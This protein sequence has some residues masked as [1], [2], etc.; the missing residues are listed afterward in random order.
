MAQRDILMRQKMETERLL[1][2]ERNRPGIGPWEP[3]TVTWYGP[4]FNGKI[5]ADGTVYNQESPTCA[6]PTLPLGTVLIVK[7]P[8]GEMV[9]LIVTDR[10]PNPSNPN[11]LDVSR[12]AARKLGLLPYGKAQMDVAA[13]KTQI[14]TK[15]HQ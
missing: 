12:F 11:R 10:M 6:S 2:E 15:E 3:L 1:L 4:G 9:P 7:S 5:A 13:V 8:Y 14:T